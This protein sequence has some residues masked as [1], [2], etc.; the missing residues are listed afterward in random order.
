MSMARYF[1][2]RQSLDSPKLLKPPML[3]FF[4]ISSW[5]DVLGEDKIIE[6]WEKRG[7]PGKSACR[8][9]SG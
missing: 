8:V 4:V 5:G 9:R 3:K 2:R 1:A 6:M 7:L